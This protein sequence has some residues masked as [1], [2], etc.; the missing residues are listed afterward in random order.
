MSI[1]NTNSEAAMTTRNWFC[2]EYEGYQ[3]DGTYWDEDG[4]VG[5]EE[6]FINGSKRNALDIVSDSTLK[7]IESQIE[8]GS[9]RVLTYRSE[10]GARFNCGAAA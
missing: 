10:I 5:I 4:A 3:L 6:I 2:T 9:G 7:H 8:A 1:A